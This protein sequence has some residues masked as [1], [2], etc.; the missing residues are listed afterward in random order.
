MVIELLEKSPKQNQTKPQ[1]YPK[2]NNSLFSHNLKFNVNVICWIKRT[3]IKSK[4]ANIKKSAH[5]SNLSQIRIIT[6]INV[7][8]EIKIISLPH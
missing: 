6:T 4:L 8:K 3:K 2:T 5:F 7:K 1:P